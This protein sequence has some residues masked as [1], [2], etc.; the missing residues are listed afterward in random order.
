MD[1][2]R[3][4]GTSKQKLTYVINNVM[5]TN[6]YGIIN[7]YRVLEAKEL[8]KRP[9][10]QNY[11]IDAISQMVGFQ[12]KSSFN[13]CFRKITGLTPSEFRKNNGK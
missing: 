10:N 1:I 5:G 9:E 13:G 4:I 6:F 11:N 2:A 8:L 3:K 7:K 12:S